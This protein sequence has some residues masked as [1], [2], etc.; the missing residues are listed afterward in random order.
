MTKQ[1]LVVD[2]ETSIR[3]LLSEALGR[4]GYEVVLAASGEEALE[5]LGQEAGLL[6]MLLDLNLPGLDGLELA[7]R[8]RRERPMAILYAMTGYSSL[9]E[10]ADCREAGF[11]D[12]FTKPLRLEVLVKALGQAFDRLE[13]WKAR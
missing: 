5:R 12:Y 9:F 3:E 10:L 11:D 7:R 6:V 2:D 1:L 8:I 4:A 13:R